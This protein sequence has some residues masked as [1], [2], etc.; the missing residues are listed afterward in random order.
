MKD[1][2]A[3]QPE[4]EATDFAILQAMIGRLDDYLTRDRLYWPMAVETP[5][6]TRWPTM[7]IGVVLAYLARL[8]ALADRLTPEQCALLSHAEAEL[9]R[10][11][12]WYPEAYRAHVVQELQS[13]LHSWTWFLDEC[14][15]EPEK[16]SDA[17][18]A[19]VRIRTHIQL[20]IDHLG[21]HMI[22]AEV[23]QQLR[24]LD[25]RLQLWFQPSDFIWASELVS[26][27]PRER[28]W[29]LYGRLKVPQD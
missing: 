23:L 22:P 6:G 29:W 7:S 21:E 4:Q 16:C 17:Y 11:R 5:A 19:E 9:Q 3:V 26:A 15:E 2:S 25:C 8:R 20:L 10:A 1:A 27:F 28:F 12:R 18:P 14:V 24:T 13:L